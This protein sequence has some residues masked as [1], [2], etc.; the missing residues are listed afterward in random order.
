MIRV[1]LLV[2]AIGLAVTLF[3]LIASPTL[4][5]LALRNI[6]RRRGEAALIIVGSMFGTAVIGAALIVGDSFD[7]SIRDVA[8]TDLGP[9]DLT[10]IIHGVDGDVRRTVLQVEDRIAHSGIDH[11]DGLL[12]MVKAAAVLD[13]RRRDGGQ[14]IDP[15]NCLAEID[16]AQGRRFGPD[17][18]I[19]GLIDAGSTPTAG[20]AVMGRQTADQLGLEAGDRFAAHLYGQTTTLELRAVVPS[21]GLVGYCGA[22]VSPG[23]IERLWADRSESVGGEGPAG[24]L[25]VSLDGAVFDSV[26]YSDATADALSADLGASRFGAAAVENA[27]VRATKDRRLTNAENSGDQLR[28]IFSAIGAFSVISGILLLVNLMIML[29]EERKSE[30][31]MLRAVGLKRGH[32][33][34]TFSLEGSIY[35]AASALLGSVVAI[36]VGALV[37]RGTQEIFAEPD[38]TFR[39]DLFVPGRTLV[40]TAA[41]GYAISLVTVWAAST[42]VARLNILSAIRD[43]PDPRRTGRRTVALAAS[44][45]GVATGVAVSI[46]GITSGSQLPLLAGV[47]VAALC[48]IPIASRLLPG[49]L[50]SVA[51]PAISIGWTLGAFTV[52]PEEMDHAGIGVFVVM[53]V[54]LVT[55]AVIIGVA[56]APVW[57]VIARR[58]NGTAALSFRLGVAYPLARRVRTGLLVAMFSLV[59]FTM[60]FMASLA[61]TID[62]Q[63]S[64]AADELDA[65]YDLVVDTNPSNPATAE[66]SEAYPGVADATTFLRSGPQFTNRYQPDKTRWAVSGFDEAMLRHELPVLSERLSRFSDSRA[67]YDAVLADP[68]LIIVDNLFLLGGGGPEDDGPEPG[69]V[70]EMTNI[71]GETRT[72]TVAGVLKADF[73]YQGSLWSREAVSEFLGPAVAE[74]RAFLRLDDG[75]DPNEAARTI[76]AATVTAGTEVHTFDALVAEEL[77]ETTAFMRLL[78]IYLGFGLLIGIAGLGV[79]MIRAARERRREVAML[80]AMG[81]KGSVI[82]R[83]FLIEAFFIAG[84]GVFIGTTLALI[85]AYQVVVKSSAFTLSS[86]NF[87]VDWVT[88]ALIG[89]I[90]IGC[91]LAAAAYPARAVGRIRPAEGLRLP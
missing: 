52:F 56:V 13:N 7:G 37:I 10:V 90:P 27:E 16:F 35:A 79:V 28:S 80:R 47:A 88:I 31:G 60:V 15:S 26:R 70:L 61:A 3:E 77:S 4:R 21:V 23:T 76:A 43:L 71:A 33:L 50:V 8:R 41:I 18:A 20:Q 19:G 55:S 39:I 24:E 32:L 38:S 78:E 91:S 42:R 65:G 81:L 84:Q 49:P 2:A 67:V 29:A 82:S 9:I 22:L 46:V 11:I 75:V 68:S 53:G 51:A 73:I 64:I 45:V 63:S 40:A 66:Q 74:T 36:G 5:R 44:M 58:L 85:T 87:T 62:D 72:V 54:L 34:R 57:G 17:D 25:Q 14:R 30:L 12:P 89:I 59:V 1:A 69:D 48:L 83:A 6:S 86:S